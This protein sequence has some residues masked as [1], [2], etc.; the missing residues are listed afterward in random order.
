MDFD[1]Q[2]N[3]SCSLPMSPPFR[4]S[5]C[6]TSQVSMNW[7]ADCCYA[8]LF[9]VGG[10]RCHPQEKPFRFG[11]R[12]RAASTYHL[13]TVSWSQCMERGGGEFSDET[14]WAILVG[15][16]KNAMRKL[17]NLGT[18]VSRPAKREREREREW[19]WHIYIHTSSLTSF[20]GLVAVLFPMATPLHEF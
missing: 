15:F 4:R 8:L 19:P 10:F 18:N 20:V 12:L 7:L 16:A 17:K 1:S 13:I 14:C 3:D 2:M 9:R 5:R 11:S 6:Y